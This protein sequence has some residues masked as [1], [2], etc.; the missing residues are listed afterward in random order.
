MP[1]VWGQPRKVMDALDSFQRSRPG[2]I[3]VEEGDFHAPTVTMN[4]MLQAV[5]G[6]QAAP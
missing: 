3:G 6:K 1:S 4:L 2:R 5:S